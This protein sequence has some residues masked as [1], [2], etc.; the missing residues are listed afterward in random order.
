MPQQATDGR[1]RRRARNFLLGPSVQYRYGLY[2]FGVAG[3][4]AALTQF[5]LIYAFQ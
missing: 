5:L 4:A 1:D 2:F 3:I